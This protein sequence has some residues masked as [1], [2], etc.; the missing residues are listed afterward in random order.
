MS[1]EV[2]VSLKINTLKK[3][4]K[5]IEEILRDFSKCLIENRF[6][7]SIKI[8]K[9]QPLKENSVSFDLR[10]SE[11][12]TFIFTIRIAEY[13]SIIIIYYDA[14]YNKEPEKS[15][16]SLGNNMIEKLNTLSN[17]MGKRLYEMSVKNISWEVIK[18]IRAFIK[19][20]YLKEKPLKLQE[21]LQLKEVS[22]V[23]LENNIEPGRKIVITQASG[24]KVN[25]KLNENF[26]IPFTYHN[27]VGY[28]A[29]YEITNVKIIKMLKETKR[30]LRPNPPP[31]GDEG[32]GMWIFNGINP[33]KSDII[34]YKT[35]RGWIEEENKIMVEIKE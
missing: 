29:E 4:Q 19:E 35:F 28:E 17:I 8:K 9:L 5:P 1:V 26:H 32:K 23:K 15:M 18:L 16:I 11:S 24:Q 27:S 20:Q 22:E 30:Y 34:V 25:L 10:S 13:P 3:P 33:G 31:G 2:T 14:T 21:M 12:P 7:R 6:E